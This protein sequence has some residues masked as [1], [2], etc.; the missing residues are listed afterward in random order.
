MN[1]PLLTSQFYHLEIPFQKLFFASFGECCIL[2]QWGLHF[3]Y[4][5]HK[6]WLGLSLPCKICCTEIV[7]SLRKTSVGISIHSLC[8]PGVSKRWKGTIYHITKLPHVLVYHITNCPKALYIT[9]QNCPKPHQPWLWFFNNSFESLLHCFS[10]IKVLLISLCLFV[11][12]SF[13]F[14]FSFSFSPFPAFPLSLLIVLFLPFS[15]KVFSLYIFLYI[16]N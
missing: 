10:L 6:D 3:P 9:Q 12:A 15:F 4:Q 13:F 1:F 16:I 11:S 8:V 2:F 7:L 14:L 5:L